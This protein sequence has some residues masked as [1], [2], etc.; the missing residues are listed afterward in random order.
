MHVKCIIT[1]QTRPGK[2]IETIF[3][4]PESWH[5]LE[6]WMPRDPDGWGVQKESQDQKE[7]EMEQKSNHRRH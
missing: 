6:K 5:C 4:S 2:A 1:D 7:L 3:S